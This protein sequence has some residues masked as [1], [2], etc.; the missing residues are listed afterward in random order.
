VQRSARIGAQW[1]RL[2]LHGGVTDEL[3]VD[4]ARRVTVYADLIDALKGARQR[5]GDGDEAMA[6]RLLDFEKRRTC[7][8][9]VADLR[10]F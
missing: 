3:A 8:Q 9:A 5:T 6:Q 1:G 10:Q 4:A 7:W 2:K